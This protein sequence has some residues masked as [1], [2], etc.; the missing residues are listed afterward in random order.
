MELEFTNHEISQARVAYE[1][2]LEMIPGVVSVA[3]GGR[4]DGKPGACLVLRVE[5]ISDS[6]DKQ[7]KE[8]LGEI[9]F[10]QHL[11]EGARA[12]SKARTN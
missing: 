12:G 1:N 3:I 8:V 7:A 11:E 6:I 10:R 4:R 5:Q 2:R 9:P